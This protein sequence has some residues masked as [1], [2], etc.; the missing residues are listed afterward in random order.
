MSGQVVRK[1]LVVGGGTVFAS[2]SLESLLVAVS[3]ESWNTESLLISMA[4]TIGT[5]VLWV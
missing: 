3:G 5:I 4:M 1:I 2:V